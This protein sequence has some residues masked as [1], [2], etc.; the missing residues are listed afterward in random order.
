MQLGRRGIATLRVGLEP[1]E[2]AALIGLV[3]VFVW[4]EGVRALEER[5]VPRMIGRAAELDG[6]T[7]T[8]DRVLAPLY[9]MSL[10]GAKRSSRLRAWAG[11][12]LIV[13]AVLAVRTMPEPWRGIVD[14][15][16]A[17]ALLW[18]LIAIVRQATARAA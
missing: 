6:A 13:T 12:A 3:L 16:V 4:G 8:R 14:L 10:I 5:W 1:L 15:S 11:V 9:A 2:W 17:S 7:R 18:G